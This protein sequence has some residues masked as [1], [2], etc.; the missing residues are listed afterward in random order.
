MVDESPDRTVRLSVNLN[1]EVADIFKTLTSRKGLSITDGI[2]RA[3]TVWKFFEDE[4]GRGN[5]I[6]I[7]E[8]DGTVWKVHFL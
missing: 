2:R 1:S 8:K 3:I 7:I 5:E 6:A 4:R